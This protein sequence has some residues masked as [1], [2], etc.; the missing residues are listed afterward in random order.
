M[1]IEKLRIVE[2]KHFSFHKT[3][4]KIA[5]CHDQLSNTLRSCLFEIRW[6]KAHA[7][8]WLASVG[9]ESFKRG[10]ANASRHLG[11]GCAYAEE[12]CRGLVELLGVL[13][14]LQRCDQLQTMDNAVRPGASAY[15]ASVWTQPRVEILVLRW[16]LLGFRIQRPAK[17]STDRLIRSEPGGVLNTVTQTVL[18]ENDFHNS[19]K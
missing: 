7:Y 18:K 1:R 16:L 6:T 3:Q 4:R 15:T 19:I 10:H 14:S 13:Q 17:L 12:L 2:S 9:S 8:L 11:V 5:K